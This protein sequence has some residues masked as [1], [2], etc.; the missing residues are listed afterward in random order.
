MS[1]FERYLSIITIITIGTVMS[2]SYAQPDLTTPVDMS[3][4]HAKDTGYHFVYHDFSAPAPQSSLFRED[5]S[6]TIKS[7]AS[8]RHYRVW[9]AIPKQYINQ[10][11]TNN[12]VKPSTSVLYILDGN[13][14]IGDL[15][16]DTML[17]LSNA[18]PK[19]NA[20]ALVF[21]GY[22][23]PYRFD[24]DARAY[25]YTPPLLTQTEQRNVFQE[26]GRERLN[27]GAEYFSKLIEQKIKPWVYLQLG[28]K[29]D[30]E[31][32]WGHSYGGLFVLYNLL[33]HPESYQQ[34]FS[35]DPSLWWQDGEMLRYWKAYQSSPEAQRSDIYENKRLR[36]TFSQAAEQQSKI[37][38]H[39]NHSAMAPNTPNKQDFA[40]QLCHD[41]QQN[42]RYQFYV[43]SHGELF[44]TSLLDSLQ[45][46]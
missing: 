16:K 39:R 7:Y 43:Q 33:E 21:I 11:T 22:Q 28:E 1:V 12:A 15:T 27:G 41:F 37:E 20:P 46:F 19:N 9:L 5:S 25:D 6:T 30:Q 14:A 23:T 32:L 38:K 17:S 24:V 4:L 13:A 36:L 34:Y 8:P 35:A 3:L 42:C 31:G 18:T 45:R 29:P 10:Q 40:E 2:P 44:K 26:K